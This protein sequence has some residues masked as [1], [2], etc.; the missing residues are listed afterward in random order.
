MEIVLM[1]STEEDDQE[2]QSG[3]TNYM[4]GALGLIPTD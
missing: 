1:Q 4:S 2:D 3:E